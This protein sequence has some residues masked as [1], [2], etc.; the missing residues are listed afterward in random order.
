MTEL[1]KIT[2]EDVKKFAELARIK[3]TDEE[4]EKF[5]GQFDDIIPFI[6]QISQR[7]VSENVIRDFNNLNT[8]RED[9]II[10]T[11]NQKRIISEMPDTENNYLKVKKILN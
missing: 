1:K 4:A 3:I 5:S 8:L 10:E 9:E 11:N 6:S 2:K 7:E